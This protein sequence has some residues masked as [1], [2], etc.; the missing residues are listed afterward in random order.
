[1]VKKRQ[2]LRRVGEQQI[3]MSNNFLIVFISK[4]IICHNIAFFPRSTPFEENID[5][6]DQVGNE[7]NVDP[8]WETFI[9]E[10]QNFIIFE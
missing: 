10:G 9:L 1:M 3:M 5:I 6:D 4:E 2:Q 7:I 8:V